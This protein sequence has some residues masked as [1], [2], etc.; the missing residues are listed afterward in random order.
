MMGSDPKGFS[1][2]VSRRQ[3]VEYRTWPISRRL[4]W[5]L[6]GNKLR[7]SLPENTIR[8]QDAFRNGER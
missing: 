8:I 2:T 4:A 1:Y 6:A 5:L 3:I 7:K